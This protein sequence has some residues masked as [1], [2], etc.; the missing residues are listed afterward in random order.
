MSEVS[1][2]RPG[3]EQVL[4]TT[5]IVDNLLHD[6]ANVTIALSLLSISPC[7]SVCLDF[8]CGARRRRTK[9][10]VLNWAG[11]LFRRVL[12]VKMDPRPLR[13]FLITRPMATLYVRKMGGRWNSR[14]CSD[15]G[16]WVEIRLTALTRSGPSAKYFLPALDTPS[17]T[18]FSSFCLH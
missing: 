13:W 7:S 6:A 8:C 1:P 3:L 4:T 11:A 14:H 12:A 9:S 17:T 10:R 18:T 5:G 15:R 2:K 16:L